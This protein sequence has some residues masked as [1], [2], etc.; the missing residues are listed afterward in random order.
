MPVMQCPHGGGNSALT[1]RYRL[2]G[3]P[4]VLL[5]RLERGPAGH[6]D[7][8]ILSSLLQSP[9]CLSGLE[10]RLPAPSVGARRYLMN[11]R[12]GRAVLFGLFGRSSSD[13]ESVRDRSV[14]ASAARAAVTESVHSLT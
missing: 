4:S 2:K 5:Y 10:F 3:D 6:A 14:V 9:N 7:V 8:M 13:A 12:S 11:P 1:S